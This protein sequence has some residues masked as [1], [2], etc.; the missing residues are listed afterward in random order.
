MSPGTL[1]LHG[2]TGTTAVKD[3]SDPP[4]APPAARLRILVEL[5][6]QLAEATPDLE[7]VLDAATARVVE[8]L[9][10]GCAAYL[11]TP[12]E[13]WLDPVSIRHRDPARCALMEQVNRARRLRVGEGLAGGVVAS[14]VPL[15]L[16]D[17]EP[18]ALRGIV[19]PEYAAYLER[20]GIR[21]L[22]VVPLSGRSRVHGALWLARDPGS[23]AYTPEDRELVEAMADCAAMALDSARL[24]VEHR[25]DRRRLAQAVSRLGKLQEVTAALSRA[26]TPDEV[27]S[28]VAHLAV[29]SMEGVAGS[30]MLPNEAGDALEMVAHVGHVHTPHLVERF[31]E[32]P[33]T[34]ANP[35]AR[36]F[37]EG[38]AIY[39][40]DVEHYGKAYPALLGAATE[41]GY[42][43]AA[44][45]PLLAHGETL[46]VLWVR[47]ATSRSFA[48][49]E[50]QLMST[51]V[52]QAAQALERARLY[53]RA[54]QAVT[55]RDEFLSVAAHELRT[56]ITAV[57]LQLQSLQ[58]DLARTPPGED[59][60]ARFIAKAD[61]VA[62]QVKRLELLVDELLNLSRLT[63]GKL[64][65]HFEEFDLRE[66]LHEVGERMADEL[67][68]A[69][70]ALTLRA[71]A[72]AVGQW[73]R[74]R[75]DQVLSNLLS[76]A[77]KY[78]AG[79][80]IEVAVLPDAHRV[81][82][83][84]RDGGVG[85]SPEDQARLFERF[86]RAASARNY[87][88]FGVGLW[89]CKQI[90]QALGGEIQVAS[91]LGEGSTFE[92]TL[93]RRQEP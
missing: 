46:G 80:P 91:R 15:Y 42:E 20:V 39:F 21:S 77:A 72:P 45:L 37:R 35:V 13:A 26:A 93:P 83:S 24:Q 74:R 61:M 88:G 51:M 47:F 10:D 34:A 54:Q 5:S 29:A 50:R 86:E 85:I 44:A 55:L 49:E 19:V 23:G 66:L 28:I 68:L 4:V 2:H 56:P 75:L 63:S 31:R 53:T 57:K 18:V 73:D 25:G 11:L 43:A 30:L 32:L 33:I 48:P 87:S 70:C 9:G 14:G 16:P 17:T 58:R 64:A 81:R 40:E 79:Q 67:T 12:D 59:S 1:P 78:G 62:R 82:L 90:V 38:T 41:A 71:D 84:V 7:T 27:A 22:L 52:A 89:I 36:V 60:H 92:V 6:R 69:G 76:N 3:A 8:L 65:L